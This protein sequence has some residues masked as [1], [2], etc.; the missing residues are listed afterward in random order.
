[1]AWFPHITLNVLVDKTYLPLSPRFCS[2]RKEIL[3]KR[4][5][6]GGPRRV[7]EKRYRVGSTSFQKANWETHRDEEI[8]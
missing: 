3:E 4:S 8:T 6:V 7:G 1:M 2:M 5:R